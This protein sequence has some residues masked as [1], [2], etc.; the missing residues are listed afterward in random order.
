[1][2]GNFAYTQSDKQTQPSE[3]AQREQHKFA[4]IHLVYVNVICGRK[5]NNMRKGMGSL[6][7]KFLKEKVI[8]RGLYKNLWIRNWRAMSPSN[9]REL[10][11]ALP[12]WFFQLKLIFQNKA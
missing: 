3:N 2:A 1:M 12:S 11:R 4:F 7:I 5:A 10:H 6:K 9:H 8:R